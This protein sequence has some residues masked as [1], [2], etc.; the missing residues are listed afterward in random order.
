MVIESGMTEWTLLLLPNSD[1]SRR[2]GLDVEFGSLSGRVARSEC[3]DG[4]ARRMDDRYQS[5]Y[6]VAA[7]I[8]R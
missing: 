3:V 1:T 6:R 4:S 8:E 7:G 5:P 2:I